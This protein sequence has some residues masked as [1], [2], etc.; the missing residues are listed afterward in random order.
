MLLVVLD[1]ASRAGQQTAD[2][3]YFLMFG[4][5]RGLLHMVDSFGGGGIRSVRAFSTIVNHLYA[6]N[7]VKTGNQ[8]ASGEDDGNITRVLLA[9]GNAGDNRRPE[10]IQMAKKVK[11]AI[12]LII[13]TI[14]RNQSMSETRMRLLAMTRAWRA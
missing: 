8:S 3:Q 5:A 7:H 14:P 13:G 1:V 11:T 9:L 4:D 12:S 6:A 10:D 2:D